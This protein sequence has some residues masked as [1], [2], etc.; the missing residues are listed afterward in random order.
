MYSHVQSMFACGC[1]QC[2]LYNLAASVLF[3]P[4][5]ASISVVCVVPLKGCPRVSCD[6]VYSQAAR[7]AAGISG[8][9]NSCYCGS[10]DWL[11]GCP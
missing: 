5:C 6:E 9:I 2:Q 3:R 11:P 10:Y 1:V 7:L 8:P 4:R